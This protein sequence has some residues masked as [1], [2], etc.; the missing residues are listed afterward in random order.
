MPGLALQ[1]SVPKSLQGLDPGR[2]GNGGVHAHRYA[3]VY[4]TYVSPLSRSDAAR[5][6]IILLQPGSKG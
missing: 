4:H 5:K 2:R 3:F 1:F 6:I